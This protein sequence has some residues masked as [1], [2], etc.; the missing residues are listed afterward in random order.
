L[1]TTT[2]KIALEGSKFWY[3]VGLKRRRRKTG[4]LVT[5]EN[6]YVKFERETRAVVNGI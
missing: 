3:E 2:E 5:V 6:V 1:F 4:E